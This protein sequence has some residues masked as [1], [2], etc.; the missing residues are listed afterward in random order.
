MEDCKEVKT[1]VR[2]EM[3]HYAFVHRIQSC[4]DRFLKCLQCI[5]FT[6]FGFMELPGAM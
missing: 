4:N 6:L 3:E 1:M 5:S 2:L